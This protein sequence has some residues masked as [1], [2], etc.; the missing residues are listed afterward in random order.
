MIVNQYPLN[1]V[2]LGY[3]MDDAPSHGTEVVS[4]NFSILWS[5]Q[6]LFN[7]VDVTQYL[8]GVVRVEREEGARC[9]A[10]VNLLM[11]AG[12]VNPSTYIG[13]DVEI[14]YI[15]RRPAGDLMSLRFKGKIESPQF[16]LQTRVLSCECSDRLNETVEPMDIAAIDALVGGLWSEDVFE[17]TEGR[18]RWVY[19]KERLSTRPASLQRSVEGALE[20]TPWAADPVPHWL[21]PRDT[22]IFQSV[23]YQPV[24][25]SER[26]NVVEIEGD[27]RFIRLRER[28]QKFDWK[29]P[30]IA[31]DAME[32]GFCLWTRDSTDLPTVGMVTNAS[33]D[34]GYTAI[35]ADPFWLRVPSTGVYCD[36]EVIWINRYPDFILRASWTSALRWSQRVTEQYVLRLEAS[37][38]V[39]QA[40]EVISRER[41]AMDTE[42]DLEQTFLAATY[43][44]PEPDAVQDALGDWVVDI[45]NESRR[46]LALSCSMEAGKTAILESHRANRFAFTLPTAEALGIRLEHTVRVEDEVLGHDISC[47]AKVYNITDE[48][49]LTSGRCYTSIQLAVS[50][51]GGNVDDTLTP[52]APPY[53]TP[54]GT[55]WPDRQLSTQLGG[56]DESPEYDPDMNGFSGNYA[57][58]LP[59]LE[60]FPWDFK[61]DVPEIPADHMDEY[62]VTSA[63]TYYLTIPTDHL[64]L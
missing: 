10:D 32:V 14:Y 48:M 4:A 64:E 46:Q 7:S 28:H 42:S 20:V 30:D 29:H 41:L 25:L 15:H 56:R 51:G 43:T 2:P 60:T 50:Q 16:N 23:E 55:G 54:P 58:R 24:Q 27:Y 47:Q 8:V 12:T 31:G 33:S 57:N 9:I 19:A 44:A 37:V 62:L 61:Y 49:D 40:G 18:S 3:G 45:R 53:S 59:G 26:I 21:V 17:P 63:H 39:A 22:V 34:A 11:D 6:V 35:L 36:P 52:P 1:T 5:V 13:Q 38:S